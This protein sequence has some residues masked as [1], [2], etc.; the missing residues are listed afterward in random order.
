MKTLQIDAEKAKNLYPSS[1][2]EFK[3]MLEDSFGKEFFSQKITDRIKTFEDACRALK[4]DSDDVSVRVGTE[5]GK[6]AL[7]LKAYSKLIIIARALNEGWEPNWNN[8]NEYKYYPYF[9]MRSG[10]GFS[11]V[12]Y[13][14]WLDCSTFGSRLCFKSEELAKYAGKQFES[15]YKDFLIL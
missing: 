4:L 10:A 11:F 12:Y 13:A 7:S 9:D 8:S 1:S 3:T 15:I 5:L 2:K 6:D 14:G